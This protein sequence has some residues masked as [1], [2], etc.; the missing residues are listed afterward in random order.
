M[1]ARLLLALALVLASFARSSNAQCGSWSA[2][3]GPDTNAMGGRLFVHDN[4]TGP[5]VYASTALTSLCGVPVTSRVV[6]WSGSTWTSVGMLVDFNVSQFAGHDLGS[7]TRL[8]VAGT[9]NPTGF[10]KGAVFM[11]DGLQWLQLGPDFYN[12]GFNDLNS[13]LYTM[14]VFDFG[15]GPKLVVGGAFRTGTSVY[16][17]ANVAYWNGA[18]WVALGA[19]LNNEIIS[20]EPAGFVTAL[21]MADDGAGIVL[22]AGGR[23]RGPHPMAAS[24]IARYRNGA[25]QPGPPTLGDHYEHSVLSLGATPA[26]NG[27]RL[28]AAGDFPE[29][30]GFVEYV[31]GA[32]ST[33]G[34]GF[35]DPVQILGTFDASSGLAPGLWVGGRFDSAGGNPMRGVAR[36]DGSAWHAVGDGALI[37]AVS[38]VV[39]FDSGSGVEPFAM[40]SERTL[41]HLVSGVWTLQCPTG[42]GASG[43]IQKLLGHRGAHADPFLVAAGELTSIAGSG[44]NRAALYSNGAWRDLF[45]E[46]LVAVGVMARLDLGDGPAV[47][48]GGRFGLLNNDPTGR[49][50][51]LGDSGGYVELPTLG[52]APSVLFA[53]DSGA[54]RRLYA[55]IASWLY[56]LDGSSW[57]LLFS[58]TGGG[59]L[60]ALEH[61]DGSGPAVFFAGSFTSINGVPARG[62]VRWNGTTFDTLGH[63]GSSPM[64]SIQQLCKHDDGQGE[65]LYAVGPFTTLG[66]VPC[67]HVARWDGSAWSEVGGGLGATTYA[68]TLFSHDDGSGAGVRLVIAGSFRSVYGAP[69]NGIAAWDGTTWSD[70]NGGLTMN[71]TYAAIASGLASI[72]FGDG[73]GA[74]LFVG[75][76]FD[77][78][79]GTPSANLARWKSCGGG[80]NTFCYGDG[81][82]TACPCANV[83]AS[84]DRAGCTHSM[85]E[86]GRLRALGRAS[87]SRD[88]LL[89]AGSGLPDSFALYFQGVG[90]ANGG[91][92][93]PFGDGIECA[94]GP[95]IRLGTY[96]NVDGV[97]QYP[98]SV[99]PSVS[100]RGFV[101]APGVRH[102]QVRYRN[103]AA[104]CSS[105]TFNYTNGLTVTWGV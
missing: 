74:D 71:S 44:V 76:L 23:F 65:D 15:L 63:G 67:E 60:R 14:G 91:F 40:T 26:A 27:S 70:F 5:A 8:F 28:V 41:V 2:E 37:G 17:P 93:V 13:S 88:S 90:L 52:N 66:G 105:D 7:G 68:T 99:D 25:W 57:T 16:S 21:A 94:S 98:S 61:D 12:S 101:G 38:S 56:R 19:G 20:S 85:G 78:A 47:F 42:A 62:I 82:A 34:G 86:G 4:G 80:A 100:L 51:R 6:R 64:A 102:Y 87:I 54:G 22:W 33:L 59:I 29:G 46:P 9:K 1:N 81:S 50:R 3:Y 83:S 10:P 24:N 72:D 31:N 30:G 75:G 96:L 32:W 95:F 97:S 69:G 103:A 73:R 53:F 18:A 48:V 49:V 36:W 55:V 35:G 77:F 104:F 84:V 11:W 79:A 89:L 58:T 39:P 92:G 45:P 43:S